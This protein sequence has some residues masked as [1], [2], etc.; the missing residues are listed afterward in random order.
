MKRVRSSRIAL[1]GVLALGLAG[2]VSG[3][4]M[5]TDG[6]SGHRKPGA[7]TPTTPPKECPAPPGGAEG[8]G[9]IQVRDDGKV[10]VDGKVV[11]RA[12]KPGEPLLVVVKDGKVYVGEEAR[13]VAPDLPDDAPPPPGRPAGG[14][15]ASGDVIVGVAGS[16]GAPGVP[17]AGRTV[18]ARG[19]G[20]AGDGPRHDCM[21]AVAR[22]DQDRPGSGAGGA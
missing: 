19:T 7:S 21:I 22:V 8:P 15:S 2:S 11:G 4:A 3:S 18:R 5:A 16:D 9:K 13:Q 1:V 12:P 10:Y 20:T 14:D 17:A 6:T